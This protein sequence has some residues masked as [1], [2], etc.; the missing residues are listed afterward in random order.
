[1]SQPPVLAELGRERKNRRKLWRSRPWDEPPDF[2]HQYDAG[3]ALWLATAPPAAAA[4]VAEM[5]TA[6]DANKVRNTCLPTCFSF[7]PLS[8]P[9][10]TAHYYQGE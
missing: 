7:C 8:D 10:A 3:A 6:P 2:T 1:M 9:R 5:F 4:A